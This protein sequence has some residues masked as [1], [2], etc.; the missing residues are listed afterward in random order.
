MFSNNS[1]L[2]CLQ[3]TEVR[4][5]RDITWGVITHWAAAV[6]LNL[7]LWTSVWPQFEVTPREN[8]GFAP[9]LVVLRVKPV[10]LTD[11]MKRW[12]TR[13]VQWKRQD[14]TCRRVWTG[15]DV[16]SSCDQPRNVTW[17]NVFLPKDKTATA[18]VSSSPSE[19]NTWIHCYL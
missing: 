15:E 8:A 3:Q 16:P 9:R 19:Y 2:H 1:S 10:T 13:T 6:G 7:H 12:G 14:E 5:H 11:E 18:R 4:G 17:A